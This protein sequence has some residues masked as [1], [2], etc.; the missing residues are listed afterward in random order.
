MQDALYRLQQAFDEFLSNFPGPVAFSWLLR[1][2]V[3]PLGKRCKPPADAL[4][5]QIAQLIMEPGAVRDRLTAGIYVPS[6]DHEPL[7]ELEQALQ[8]VIECAPI[9]AKLREAT[10][11]RQIT[12]RGDEKIAQALQ[13]KIITEA[14][15]DLLNKLKDLRSRV[16]KVDDFPADFGPEIK[17]TVSRAATQPVTSHIASV[18]SAS[19]SMDSTASSM[20]AASAQRN[21]RQESAFEAQNLREIEDVSGSTQTHQSIQ[22]V[23]ESKD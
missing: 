17:T 14:E 11:S 13:L 16:I 18:T 20:D 8:C 10:K 22:T 21:E 9:E 6:A 19:D 3:F 15:A 4:A 5:H 2:L 7:A 12:A 23:I 1:G